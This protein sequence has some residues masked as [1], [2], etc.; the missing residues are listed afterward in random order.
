MIEKWLK[1][2]LIGIIWAFM[3]TGCQGSGEEMV[4]IEGSETPGETVVL[5]E[6][7]KT[8]HPELTGEPIRIGVLYALSGNNAAI[9][10]NILRGIDFAVEDINASGGVKGRPIEIVRGDTQGNEQV[11]QLE[12][13]RLITEDQVHAILGCHQSTL[14]E[15]VFEMCEQ[16]QIPAMTAISTVDSISSHNYEYAFR[17]CPM[18]SLYLENMFMYLRDQAEKTGHE[19]KTIAVFAD[20]SMIG[21]E[22]I[23]CA[24][25][26]APKYGMEVVSEIQ[27][28][29]GAADLTAEIQE[30]KAADADAVLAESYVSDAILLMDTMEALDYH[31]PI[32]IAKANGFADPSFIPAT[33]G[34]SEG[35][36][37]VVEWNPDLTK[38]QEIN[39]RFKEIFGVDMNGHSA[40]SYTAVWTLKTA[41]E[42]A[43][44]DEGEAV[45]NA[46]ASLDIQDAFPGGPEIILPYNRIKFEDHEFNGIQYYNDN[47]YASVAI[48]QIQD[49]EYKTV[50]PFE[51]SKQEIAKPVE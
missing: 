33:E 32:V 46:L 12:A 6:P 25:I 17:L 42:Q 26:Y 30:L 43:G 10:T 47:I 48:A 34:I 9:G 40:E 23:R 24:R 15:V 41:F 51:Y 18:N 44:T 35:L 21:Q 37:S 16:Y 3:L 31:P 19:V 29:Q 14:T 50:W 38:G 13:E 5:P 4:P 45:K 20:N 49:G 1:P 36:T 7:E 39:G 11:A 8:L 22:A 2:V 27:Y 28:G